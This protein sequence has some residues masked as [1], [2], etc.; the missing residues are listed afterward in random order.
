LDIVVN[1]VVTEREPPRRKRWQT[2]GEPRLIVIGRY[3]MGFEIVPQEDASRLRLWIDYEP[4]RGAFGWLPALG[5]M[6]ARWCVDRMVED[7][8]AA[9]ARAV[10]ARPSRS[11]P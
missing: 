3:E 1:E 5:Q 10:E 9:F 6:Y 7:A 2:M 8:V 11:D 4:A